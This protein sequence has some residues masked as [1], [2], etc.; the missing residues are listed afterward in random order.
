MRVDLLLHHGH[1]VEGVS[2]GVE[3]QDARELLETS[4]AKT[5]W[6]DSSFVLL[7]FDVS[8]SLTGG[9]VSP[10]LCADLLAA[11]RA[12]VHVVAL[13]GVF[14]GHLIQRLLRT[15]KRRNSSA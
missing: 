3:A 6:S 5:A 11:L 8:W 14:D 2:H 10:F 7:D 9:F 15:E 13:Q 4:P 12:G 1:H